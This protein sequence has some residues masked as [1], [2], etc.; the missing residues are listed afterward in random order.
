MVEFETAIDTGEGAMTTFV[1]HPDT[2]GRLPVALFFMDAPG[3]RA[4]LHDMARRLAAEGYYVMLP[5]LFYREVPE[6]ELDFASTDSVAEM[7]RLMMT[8]GNQMVVRDAES[9]LAFADEDPSA[10][11]ARVGCLGYCMS[12]PFAIS[13]AAAFPERVRAAVS[14]YGV[15]LAVDADDSPH[16]MLPDIA[17]ELYVACAELDDYAP[18]E[19][20]ERFEAAMAAAGTEGRLEHHPGTRHGFGFSD[21]PD[22]DHDASELLWSRVFD[23]FDRTLATP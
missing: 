14:A 6:F 12:G 3:K 8:I 7:G 20:I 11:G 22:Y 9:L 18:P 15:R 19:M 1:V 2:T 10:D 17:G 4:L 23:L 13:V 5:N 21:R 16:T